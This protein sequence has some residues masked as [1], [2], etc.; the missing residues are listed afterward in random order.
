MSFTIL[1]ADDEENARINLSELLSAK[2]YSIIQSKTL[3]ETR[4]IIQKGDADIVLLDVNFPDG[5][6]TDLLEESNS[7][8][9]KPIIIMITGHGDIEMAVE[10]MRKGAKS[11]SIDQTV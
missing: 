3:S 1:I 4:A 2:G 7:F 10:S 6:G 9:V 11:R 5:Y 8:A